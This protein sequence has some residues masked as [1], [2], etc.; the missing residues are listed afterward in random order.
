MDKVVILLIQELGKIRDV[1]CASGCLRVD[2]TCDWFIVKKKE[3]NSVL[4][5]YVCSWLLSRE[6]KLTSHNVTPKCL[7]VTCNFQM[8]MVIDRTKLFGGVCLR[9]RGNKKR[10][11]CFQVLVRFVVLWCDHKWTCAPIYSRRWGR[12]P[13]IHWFTIMEGCFLGVLSTRGS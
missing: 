3:N 6:N 10:K 9:P 12:R 7:I 2:T 1:A 8:M 5:P 13:W 4:V 11:G